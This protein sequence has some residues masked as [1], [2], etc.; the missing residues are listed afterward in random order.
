M[1]FPKIKISNKCI[2][3]EL[4][5]PDIKK[6]YYRGTRFDW[7]GI[8]FSIEYNNHQFSG[9]WFTKADPY[10]HDA[11]C[12]PVNEFAPA[13]FD[14]APIGGEFLKIGV[15]T[16]RRVSV[17]YQRFALHEIVH[18]GQ[19]EMSQGSD[20]MVFQQRLTSDVGSYRYTKTV[21]LLANEPVLLLEY[22]LENIGSQPIESHVFNHNFFVI[23]RT[24]TGPQTVIEFPF[25]PEGR[26][27][28]AVCPAETQGNRMVFTRYL[29]PGESVYMAEVLGFNLHE[30]YQ[31]RIG[32]HTAKAGVEVTGSCPPFQLSFWASY[33]TV[34]PEAFIRLSVAPGASFSWYDHYAFY[35]F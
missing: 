29:Q 11:I 3:V 2:K 20:H 6:G 24:I 26:W 4:Y 27:R 28:D 9:P 18:P 23:D 32:N 34:C 25:A 30:N 15:G 33:L 17:D 14:A 13:G 5:L 21:R 16:L 19:W 7:S 8:I 1:S 22:T 10:H 12:G 31:F 35:R